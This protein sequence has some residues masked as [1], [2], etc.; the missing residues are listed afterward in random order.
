VGE[1]EADV[2]TE[3]LNKALTL[4]GFEEMFNEGDLLV[5]DEMLADGSENH[6]EEAG[7]DFAE[8]LKDIVTKMRAAFSDLRFEVHHILAEGDI[9]ASHSTMTDTHEGRSEASGSMTRTTSSA[10]EPIPVGRI[11]VEL[12]KRFT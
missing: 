11:R 4:V 1:E 8:H 7:T 6:Q 5:G 9:V 3:E 12:G 2:S 10:L